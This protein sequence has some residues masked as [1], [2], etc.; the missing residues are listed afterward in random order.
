MDVKSVKDEP[1]LSGYDAVIMGSAIN[2]GQWLPEAVKFVEANQAELGE[3]PVA[4]FTV[5]MRN[6]GDDEASRSARHAYLDAIRPM[7][8]DAE[9]VYFE[10]KMDFSCLSFLNRLIARVVGATEADNRD[11]DKIRAWMP[12]VLEADV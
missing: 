12:E 7:L 1:G 3:M 8:N 2:M 9:E 10:G 5:H 4:L 6:V 11:W